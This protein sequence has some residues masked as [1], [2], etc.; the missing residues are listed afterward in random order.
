VSSGAHLDEDRLSALLDGQATRQDLQHVDRCREC[1]ERLAAWQDVAFRLAVDPST[2]DAP[3]RDEAVRA[4]LAAVVAANPAVAT[5]LSSGSSPSPDPAPPAG[6][7]VAPLKQRHQ[8]WTTRTRVLVVAGG[9]AAAIAVAAAAVGVSGSGGGGPG[10]ASNA[11]GPTESPVASS[12][13]PAGAGAAAPRA[14]GPPAGLGDLGALQTSSSLVGALQSRLM[15]GAA[16]SAA[17]TAPGP[18]A[19]PPCQ[20]EAAAGAGVAPQTPPQL[21]ATVTYRGESAEAYVFP[22]GGRWVAAVVGLPGCGLVTVV[23]F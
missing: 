9:I 6:A 18:A 20:A 7:R 17:G 1:T 8:R 2:P 19:R 5:S 23:R 13:P 16:S 10:P 22:A 14:S 12:L 3:Q 15:A 11:A 21:E 4:A